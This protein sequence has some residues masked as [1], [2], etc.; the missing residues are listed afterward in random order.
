MQ[1]HT[2]L[3]AK[4]IFVDSVGCS[5]LNLHSFSFYQSES[6]MRPIKILVLKLKQA[7]CLRIHHSTYSCIIV[8][9]L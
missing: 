1:T 4:L 9:L 6:P 2:K 7:D 3:P 5:N 8:Q